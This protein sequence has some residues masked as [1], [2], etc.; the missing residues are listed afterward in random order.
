[1]LADRPALVFDFGGVLISPI[2]GPIAEV[3]SWHDVSM[4]QML[5]VLMG[6]REQSTADHPWHRAERGELAV[7]ELPRL[8]EPWARSA[9]IELRGEEYDRLLAGDFETHHHLV[10]RIGDLRAEGH[11]TALL[12]NSFIEFESVRAER[13]DET[14]FDHVFD[15]ARMGCRK[16][17][18][19][20]YRAVTDTLGR[21]PGNIVYLDDF[22]ANLIP[23]NDLG[24]QCI[25]V[26]DEQAAFDELDALLGR[27]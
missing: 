15:S 16:P 5:D 23:A 25:H 21:A 6:P 11:T 1:M 10:E 3:A 13:I 4:H 12:T 8:V 2:T 9:G 17:E 24:W 18:P 27:S 26:V 7:A 19:Q 22:E 14:V 20:I